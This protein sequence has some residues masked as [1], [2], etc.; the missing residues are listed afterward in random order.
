MPFR[1]PSAGGTIHR[2]GIYARYRWVITYERAEKTRKA[3]AK[4]PVESL[5]LETDGP[6]MPLAGRQGE[7]NEPAYLPEVL[8]GLSLLRGSTPEALI[9]QTELNAEKMFRFLADNTY[10]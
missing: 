9:R 5:L 3:V 1:F 7:R 8:Q 2:T 4:L 6:T 10:H